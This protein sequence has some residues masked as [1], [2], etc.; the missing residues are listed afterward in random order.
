M[1]QSGQILEKFNISCI[2]TTRE[3]KVLSSNTEDNDFINACIKNAQD[4]NETFFYQNNFYK[5]VKTESDRMLSYW[6]QNISKL[7]EN[8][9]KVLDISPFGKLIVVSIVSIIAH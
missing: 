6:A 8:C 2:I 5:V 3:G 7:K 4:N 1:N 9:S